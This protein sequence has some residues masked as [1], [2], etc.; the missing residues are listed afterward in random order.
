[1]SENTFES[2]AGG[3]VGG[4]LASRMIKVP[5]Y[6]LSTRRIFNEKKQLSGNLIVADVTED[7]TLVMIHGD[8]DQTVT[9]SI[10]CANET[11]TTTGDEQAIGIFLG[12]V[13]IAASGNGYIPTID[14]ICISLKSQ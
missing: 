8:G 13:T 7:V 14:I 1:M 2:I 3:I 10:T 6:T 5:K 9:L 4:L 12:K 11:Y